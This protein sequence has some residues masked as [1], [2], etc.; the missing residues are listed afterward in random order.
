MNGTQT[1]TLGFAVSATWGVENEICKVVEGG[2]SSPCKAK[3]DE[4][5]K[6]LEQVRDLLDAAYELTK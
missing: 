1:T 2:V 4:A 5:I 6:L 3:L